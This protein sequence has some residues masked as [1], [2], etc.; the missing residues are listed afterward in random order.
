[1]YVDERQTLYVL[2]LFFSIKT[3][4]QDRD[5]WVVKVKELGQITIKKEN[6]S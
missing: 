5:S 3:I 2:N 4:G 1:M 6:L